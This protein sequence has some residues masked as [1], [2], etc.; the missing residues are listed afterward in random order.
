MANP[1]IFKY[2]LEL[3]KNGEPQ[4]R[5][6]I[7]MPVGAQI[8]TLQIQNSVPTIWAYVIPDAATRPR[9]F[10]KIGTGHPID[11]TA[12]LRYIGTWQSAGYVFHVFEE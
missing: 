11:T 3:I 2:P 4:D 6:T 7:D 8:L 5:C 10:R 9:T 12:D 1:T